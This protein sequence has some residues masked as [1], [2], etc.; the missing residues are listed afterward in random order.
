[1]VRSMATEL[2]DR[3]ILTLARKQ[4]GIVCRPQLTAAGI[5]AWQIDNRVKQDRLIP[6][7][8]GV[9]GVGHDCIDRE[10]RLMAAI[11]F[12]GPGSVLSHET[13][14]AHWGLLEWHGGIHVVRDFNRV[15]PGRSRD[16]W[17]I[18][19]RTRF[20]PPSETAMHNHLPV[21]SVERTLLNI[22][23][24]QPRRKVESCLTAAERLR[25]LDKRKMDKVLE[26]GPG[27]KGINMLR[28]L[29]AEWSDEVTRS[30]SDL[31][32]RFFFLCRGGGLD[33]PR[34]NTMIEGF[35]VDIF[36]PQHRL[37]VELDSRTHHLTRK[38]F[39]EDRKRDA[40][41]QAA[42]YRVVRITHRMLEQDPQ[43]AVDSVLGFIR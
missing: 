42:G 35:E 7:L 15:L 36:W 17:L 9:Y 33:T 22:A 18:V 11:L 3:K 5:H 41:L 39:E 21:T 4:R 40:V 6:I 12:A 25:L 2:A 13:A 34:V 30:R 8:P 32:E 1:M 29:M 38:A 19:H 14:A 23:A 28:A 10:T 26:R 24:T 37:I 20:L 31:E 27:W 43:S 16:S